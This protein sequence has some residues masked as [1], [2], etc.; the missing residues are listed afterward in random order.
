MKLGEWHKFIA[1]TSCF[2]FQFMKKF[3]RRFLRRLSALVMPPRPQPP[4]AK[5]GSHKK[6]IELRGSDRLLRYYDIYDMEKT[7]KNNKDTKKTLYSARAGS[8][9]EKEVKN[10]SNHD[11]DAKKKWTLLVKGID[12][13]S[14]ELV[15]E[16]TRQKARIWL[17]QIN[18]SE[19]IAESCHRKN[20]T[21]SPESK[22]EI[23]ASSEELLPSNDVIFLNSPFEKALKYLNTSFYLF[24]AYNDMLFVILPFYLMRLMLA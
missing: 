11:T 5:I 4:A 14:R 8:G 17:A 21:P 20:A 10:G 1:H 23:V 13:E 18:Q 16:E 12:W 24:P 6:C 3:L 22:P 19:I 9:D 2:T 7:L 15:S